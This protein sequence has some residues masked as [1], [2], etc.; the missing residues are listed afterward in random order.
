M[1]SSV[2]TDRYPTMQYT[3]LSAV[4]LENNTAD[5]YPRMPLSWQA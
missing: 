3:A 5:P 4:A 2:R 1:Q